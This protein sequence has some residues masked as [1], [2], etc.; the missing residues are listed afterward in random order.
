M[1]IETGNVY[2]INLRGVLPYR[3]VKVQRFSVPAI[4]FL[5]HIFFL[6]LI[7][8]SGPNKI[9]VIKNKNISVYI[10]KSREKQHQ[11]D[12]FK[13]EKLKCIFFFL[14]NVCLRSKHFHVLVISRTGSCVILL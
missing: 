13:K 3:K 1:Q 2:I 11:N 10:L 6:K 12:S 4:A 7:Q 14:N 8:Y 5:F 9:C